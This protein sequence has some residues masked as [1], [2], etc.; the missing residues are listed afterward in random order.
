MIRYVLAHSRVQFH[1]AALA[2]LFVGMFV[3]LM[4]PCVFVLS[5]IF[6]A[7]GSTGLSVDHETAVVV[8]G[9]V[10]VGEFIRG[11]V[12]YGLGYRPGEWCF[13]AIGIAGLAAGLVFGAAMALKWGHPLWLELLGWGMGM[14]ALY[15]FVGW[16]IHLDEK[17]RRTS[18]RFG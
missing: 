14:A 1:P 9:P 6:K 2:L 17:K 7:F 4:V 3:A 18:V 13:P 8:Y 11:H 15:L 10:I 12:K 16:M 5:L